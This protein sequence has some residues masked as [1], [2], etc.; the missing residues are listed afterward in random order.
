MADKQY[1]RFS[2]EDGKHLPTS[3]ASRE[4][5]VTA[6][7]YMQPAVGSSLLA[8]EGLTAGGVVSKDG[9]GNWFA[10][11][12]AGCSGVSVDNGNGIAGNPSLRLTEDL[13]AVESLTG[14]GMAKRTGA[15]AWALVAS[16]ALGETL[17]TSA[18]VQHAQQALFLGTVSTSFAPAV[19]FSPNSSCDVLNGAANET[20][21]TQAAT[22]W[23]GNTVKLGAGASAV[24]GYYI[25]F[26][27]EVRVN[28]DR[29]R[30]YVTAYDGTSKIAT[31]SEVF[32]IAMASGSTY[33]VYWP[34]LC[35]LG[36]FVGQRR[37]IMR[38]ATSGRLYAVEVFN[39]SMAHD[40]WLF[41][42]DQATE[43]V[44]E[45]DGVNWHY[46][47]GTAVIG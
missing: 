1:W 17:L 22:V 14:A 9:S 39:S 34:C 10:R 41:L 12:I 13:L 16:S 8:V 18:D 28:G 6:L 19:T 33:Y 11:A 27:I 21:T 30:R 25:G 2:T 7:E 4:Q 26:W 46:M 44:L 24:N 23:G 31:V 37:S 40:Y 3:S 45:W 5:F 38:R 15:D 20:G 42:D 35:V 29:Q 43:A 32:T 36:L 47:A